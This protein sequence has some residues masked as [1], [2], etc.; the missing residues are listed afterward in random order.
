MG[1]SGILPISIDKDIGLIP[2]A[3]TCGGTT[4]NKTATRL[5]SRIPRIVVD[6]PLLRNSATVSPASLSD[7]SEKQTLYRLR[8]LINHIV[9]SRNQLSIEFSRRELIDHLLPGGHF[10]ERID[11]TTGDAFI[12]CV[13]VHLKRRGIETRLIIS[14]G[15]DDVAHPK[16]ARAIQDALKKALSWNQA[17]VSGKVSSMSALARQEKV[18]QRYIAHLLPFAFLAPDI[19]EAIIRGDI[20]PQLSLGRLKKGLSA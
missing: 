2:L 5:P 4:H 19:M 20:P 7:L 10:A 15:K 14:E 12:A 16:T 18:T 6:K 13:P 3:P 17:L 8:K 9:I 1:R 11:T